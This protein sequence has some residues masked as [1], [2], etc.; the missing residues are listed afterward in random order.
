VQQQHHNTIF[1]VTQ[2]HVL[3]TPESKVPITV[4]YLISC[5]QTS[6]HAATGGKVLWV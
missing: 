1:P 3:R 2:Q 6:F 5:L 4:M